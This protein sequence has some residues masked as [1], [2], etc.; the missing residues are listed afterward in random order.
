MHRG[1]AARVEERIRDQWRGRAALERGHFP[2][3][4]SDGDVIEVRVCSMD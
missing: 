3:D 1:A 2:R 4:R